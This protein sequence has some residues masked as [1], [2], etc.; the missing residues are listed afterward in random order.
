MIK[1]DKLLIK[2]DKLTNFKQKNKQKVKTGKR[3]I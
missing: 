2:F 3:K 1:L